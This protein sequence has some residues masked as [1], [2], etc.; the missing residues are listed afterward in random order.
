MRSLDSALIIHLHLVWTHIEERNI[1]RLDPEKNKVLEAM[2]CEDQLKTMKLFILMKG[3]SRE[4]LVVSFRNFRVVFLK[5]IS[6]IP[7]FLENNH[8]PYMQ[9]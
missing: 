1:E 4:D 2:I 6:F 7:M 3:R 5:R 8:L 9:N